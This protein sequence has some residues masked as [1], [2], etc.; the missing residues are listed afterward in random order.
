MAFTSTVEILELTGRKRS[1]TL[2]GGGLPS[3]GAAFPQRMRLAT[4]WLPGN[5][6]EATQQVLGPE[7][8]SPEWEG[9]WSTPVLSSLPSLFEEAGDTKLIARAM[10]LVKLLDAFTAAGS[11]LRVTW[12]QDGEAIQVRE[13]RIEEFE[14]S[15]RT[16]DDVTWRVQW[17]W[18]GRGGASKRVVSLKKDGQLA[19]HKKIEAELSKLQTELLAAGIVSSNKDVLGSAS[20]FSLGQVEGFLDGIRNFTG[21][22]ASQIELFGSRIR[23]I[24]ELVRSVEELPANIAQQFVDATATVMSDCAAFKRAVTQRGPEA[25]ARFDQ[26]AGVATIIAAS[27]YLSG[28]TEAADKVVLACAEARAS[29]LAKGGQAPGSSSAQGKPSPALAGVVIARQGDT[30]AS[31]AKRVLGDPA[32]GP[33]VAR[34]SGYPWFEQ[35]PRVGEVILVPNQASAQQL[36]PGA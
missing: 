24:G 23:Q 11:K 33:A 21:A 3:H 29:L 9:Y 28:A 19:Q 18:T 34:S 4:T 2:R 31:I 25:Y 22:F 13:G 35:A 20:S 1:L 17:A 15:Y 30:F 14:P 27:R 32:L 10:T 26:S 12:Q 8:G 36:M 16:R 6:T 7:D 5:G